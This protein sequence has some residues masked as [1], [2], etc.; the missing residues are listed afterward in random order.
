MRQTRWDPGG[1]EWR[2][3]TGVDATIKMG[4]RKRREKSM[5]KKGKTLCRCGVCRGSW[6]FGSLLWL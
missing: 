2:S 5:R 4:G 3:E 6:K 1:V